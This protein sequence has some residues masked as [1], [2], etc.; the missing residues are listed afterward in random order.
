MKRDENSPI[1]L[2]G[3]MNAQTFL[4]DYWQKKP[5][6]IRGALDISA[7]NLANFADLTALAARDDV[8]SRWI[9]GEFSPQHP[10]IGARQS[11]KNSRWTLKHGAF[12]AAFFQNCPPENWTLLV[13]G[14]NLYLPNIARLLWQFDFLPFARLDDLMISYGPKGG[15]VGPHFDSY[16]VFLL[17]IGGEKRWQIS[18]GQNTPLIEGAPLK[19]LS[20][21]CAEQSWTL[22]HGD[23][24]YLPPKYAHFGVNLSAGM[25]YSIGFRAPSAQELATQ[26][27]EYWLEFAAPLDG[28]YADPD[29]KFQKNPAE[30]SGEMISQVADFL[31]KIHWTK[32]DI[33]DFLGRYLSEPKAH[34]YFDAPDQTLDFDDFAQHVAD[35][36]IELDLKSQLL[37]SGGQFYLN[38][39]RLE[40]CQD[41]N[42]QELAFWQNLAHART[43][44]G[45]LSD[46]ASEPLFDAYLAG[47]CHLAPQK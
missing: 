3:G 37:F 2:L 36:G 47:F 5:L 4:R 44:Q 9:L 43:A 1:A 26:F 35:F 22:Q 24:L 46:A 21:F 39:D 32:D 33:A 27:L 20:E 6:L 25:T 31:D 19:I 17:Q 8:E 7:D 12:S 10:D 15:T 18:G 23:M 38:G 45:V 30:I 14:V 28:R 41:L 42:A 29:L 16:D 13:Q 11:F 34:L 40:F